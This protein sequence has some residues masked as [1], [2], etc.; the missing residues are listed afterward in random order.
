MP[1][2][3]NEISLEGKMNDWGPFGEREGK[4]LIFSIG[5]PEEG[6]GYA[7]S[8]NIDDLHSQRIAHLISCKTGARYVAHIPWTTDNAGPVARDWSPKSIPVE[9]CVK[10]IIKFLNYHIQLYKEINLPA[11]RVLIYSGHGGNN[12]LVDHK[13]E[14]KD[15]LKLEKL[16][17]SSTEGIA[18][19]NVDRILIEMEKL[20]SRITPKGEDQRKIKMKLYKILMSAGHAGHFEHSLG[21]A[22]GVLDE[23]KLEVMNKALEK[24]FEAA[25]NQ[26]PP[27]GGLG[28]F[29]LKGGKYID[30]FGTK[31]E[32]KHGLWKCLNTLRRLNHGKIIVVK[33]LGELVINLLVEHYSGLILND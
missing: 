25:L 4:W 6:H 32:D 5:N 23:A 13:K 24:D 16:I 1:L 28:G 33:E 14:I 21:A 19:D 26:W 27:L 29:L 18:E 3:N 9:Q 20:S 8:R 31:K 15:A 2:E 10:N 17:I 30:A 11:S 22:L 7:L 12:P